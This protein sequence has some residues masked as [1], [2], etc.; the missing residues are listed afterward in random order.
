MDD[1]GTLL[2]NIPLPLDPAAVMRHLGK[3]GGKSSELVRASV[4]RWRAAARELLAPRAVYRP[5][6]VE[7]IA[8][9]IVALAGGQRFSGA[10]LGTLFAGAEQ[11]VVTVGT[12]GRALEEEVS[13]L[14]AAAEFMDA[15]VLD[16]IGSVAVEEVCQYVRSLLCRRY[17]DEAG[18]RVGP[19]LSPGYQYW[20]LRDQRVIFA[21]VP[22][23]A[24]GVS[25]TDSC[26]MVPQ[27][28]ESTVTPVGRNLRV[29]AGEDEPPCRFCDRHDCPARVA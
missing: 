19:S 1:N 29:T 23:E 14:F 18:L 28:S 12:I 6:A 20:D 22:A 10:R 3:S 24:I 13:R 27:K 26:L 7:G 15:V 5:F 8:D 11:L 9:G 25:L 16:A 2:Q 21:L 17:G 4:E